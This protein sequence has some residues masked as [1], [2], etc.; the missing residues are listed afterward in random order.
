MYDELNLYTHVLCCCFL[1]SAI[2]SILLSVNATAILEACAHVVTSSEMLTA[3]F[4]CDIYPDSADENECKDTT[5]GTAC[6]SKEFQCADK[7]CIP[8]QWRYDQLY[9]SFCAI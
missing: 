2:D 6:H 1:K 9:N 4:D 7:T 8:S 3:T 5:R